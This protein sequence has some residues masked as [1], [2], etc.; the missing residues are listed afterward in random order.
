PPSP[1]RKDK[2]KN[3]GGAGLQRIMNQCGATV[4]VSSENVPGK[5]LMKLITIEGQP[6]QCHAARDEIVRTVSELVEVENPL[7]LPFFSTFT[8]PSYAALHTQYR[9]RMRSRA[10][11]K[12]MISGG[13]HMNRSTTISGP[14]GNDAFQPTAQFMGAANFNINPEAPDPSCFFPEYPKDKRPKVIRGSIES[15]YVECEIPNK[16]VGL[17]IGKGAANVKLLKDKTRCDI[18]VQKDEDLKR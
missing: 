9:E 7:P 5:P 2:H 10:G 16:V 4:V 17:V 6:E 1:P 18:S 15:C 14:L 12:G 8:S 13:P 11:G 3:R